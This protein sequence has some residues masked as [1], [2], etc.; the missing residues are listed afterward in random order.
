MILAMKFIFTKAVVV[1]EG[2][3]VVIAHVF[4]ACDCS[5]RSVGVAIK[6]LPPLAHTCIVR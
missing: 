1:M 2:A 3:V 4:K 5:R 6:R